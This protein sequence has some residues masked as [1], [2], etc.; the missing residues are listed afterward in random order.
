MEEVSAAERQPVPLV[1]TLSFKKQIEVVLDQANDRA[2]QNKIVPGQR[3]NVYALFTAALYGSDRAEER[4]AIFHGP[5]P[6]S[7]REVI[8][9]AFNADPAKHPLRILIATDAARE[10]LNL[11]AHCWN[12]FHFDVP[13]NPARM[14]QRNGRIDRKLQPN[15][16]VYC[17]YFFYRQRPEDRILRAL[18]NK[19]KTIRE[20]LGSLSQVIDSRLD[21]LMKNGIR[22]RDIDALELEIDSADLEEDRRAAVE[23]ELEATRERQNELREQIEKLST[24]LEDS[25]QAIS[26]S[27]DH[28][29]SAI[30]CALQILGADP[31]KTSPN[32]PDGSQCIFPAMDQRDGADPTWAETMDSLR[33]PRPR[34]QKLWEWRRTSP[35]RPVVFEDPGVVT[36]EVVQLHLEQRAAGLRWICLNG[37]T[38]Y[39]AIKRLIW[40]G[41][42]A[43][44][45]SVVHVFRG[46]PRGPFELN[47]RAVSL[48]TAYLFHA[49]GHEDPAHIIANENGSFVGSYVLG[50]GFSFDDSDEGS[51]ASPISDMHLLIKKNPLNADRIFP[52]LGGEEVNNS[53]T[54]AHHRFVINFEDFP[55]ER[56]PDGHSWF[57]LKAETQLRQFRDGVV[58]HDYPGAVAADWPDLL[59]IVRE[60]VKPERDLKDRD[61]HRER[62]WQYA[63]KRPGLTRA[64]EKLKTVL[65]INCGACPH[66]AIARVPSNQVFAHSLVL[67]TSD[68]SGLYP[69]LQSRVHEVWARFMAS[70]MKD[71][72]RYTPSDCFETFPFPDKIESNA[73]LEAA[74]KAYYEFRAESMIRNDEGLTKT[75]NRFHDPSED[76]ADIHRLR[77]LHTAMD[78]AVL[79]AYGWQDLHPVCEFFPEFDDEEEE[80]EGGR[81]KKKKYRYRWPEEIHDEVLARLL[82]LNRQRALGEGQ[83]SVPPQTAESPWSNESQKSTNTRSRK[84]V[85]AGSP[86]PLF[87]TTEEEE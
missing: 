76:S 40:P 37:G 74:G 42:A 15:P 79:D 81:L 49:G 77:E 6:V 34:D 67:F 7:E 44:I 60:K 17:R 58:P 22:R 47:G 72:L 80:D 71:D 68:T 3:L 30:S 66:L 36:D 20:E 59:T 41:E 39:R 29:R 86:G 33:A 78:R 64:L 12:I 35:I 75:Y 38:I 48:I 70:S 9:T 13:W 55:L 83:I 31:L 53:P 8:K 26:F 43:V 56:K 73:T 51:L 54:H 85:T 1:P 87:G 19:T 61:A 2:V 16:V 5:T 69:A 82:D 18:V 57:Q 21:L 46:Q 84:S 4:I 52:Y 24:M 11:Q 28:F 32:D 62:W 23:E 65:A 63:D 45:V 14:E 50:K 25:Q 10:G 27:K